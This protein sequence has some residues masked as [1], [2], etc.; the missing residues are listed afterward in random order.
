MSFVLGIDFGT[1]NTCVSYYNGNE[2]RVLTNEVGNYT[3]PSCI[4]FDPNSPEILYGELALEK[5]ENKIYNIKRLFGITWSSFEKNTQL[6]NFFKHLHIEKSSRSEYCTI[7]IQY[8]NSLH[9]FE[10]QE[11]TTMYLNHLITYYKS[12]VDCSHDIVITVPVEFN[13]TQRTLLKQVFTNLN[14]NVLRILNEPTAATLAY[15]N[16]NTNTECQNILVVDCGGGTTDFTLLETDYDYFEVIRTDGDAFL[17]G[18]DLTD[19]LATWSLSKIK[20]TDTISTKQLQKIKE[21]CENCKKR[22]S[23]TNVSNLLLEIN[24]CDYNINVSKN[25]FETV[26]NTWF[27]KF[28]RMINQ[29]CEN[30]DVDTVILVGGTTRIPKIK[31]IVHS[32]L[33]NVK[34]HDK[35]DPDHT[36]SIG[37]AFQGY[38]L[39]GVINNT[40]ITFVDTIAMSLG[41]KTVGDLM[42]PVISKNTILPCSRTETFFTTDDDHET[43]DIE[44]YQGERRF[45]HDNLKIGTFNI[46]RSKRDQETIQITFDITSD[47]ILIVTARNMSSEKEMS[48]TFTNY[49]KTITEDHIYTDE[50]EKIDDMELSNLILAKIE[51]NNTLRLL[52]S[53]NDINK[54][55]DKSTDQ[56]NILVKQIKGVINGYEDYTAQELNNWKQKLQAYWNTLQFS[57]NQL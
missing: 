37:A 16:E 19:N 57:K 15:I 54:D 30:K 52:T 13:I 3:T 11:I 24:G 41:I 53:I 39:N 12:V 49:T 46:Q 23:W 36:I 29:L 17:G 6:Q 7:V 50:V 31:E 21:S 20:Y 35:L 8:N 47:G 1:T 18:E 40:E 14:L 55:T 51:L 28:K 56:Y 9:Y 45:I 34:I 25:M 2:Y 38:L 44:V 43:I 32:S 10:P 42:T 5:R 48:V 22:L 33:K 27:N 4:Y 26:N